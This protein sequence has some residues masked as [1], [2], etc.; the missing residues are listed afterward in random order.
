L[1]IGSGQTYIADMVNIA[2]S[3]EAFD[4]IAGAMPV[5]R[6]A[7]HRPPAWI[8]GRQAGATLPM[9]WKTQLALRLALSSLTAR[10][11]PVS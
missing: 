7:I 2:I 11:L 6:R 9:R 10:R 3:Q 5:C 4:A 1:A 8:G